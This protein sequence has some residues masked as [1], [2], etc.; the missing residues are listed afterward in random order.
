MDSSQTDA[1]LAR[2]PASLQ[3]R[4]HTEVETLV[5]GIIGA[6][7]GMRSAVTETADP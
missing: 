4:R 5:P 6:F 1:T 3:T 7:V 2:H